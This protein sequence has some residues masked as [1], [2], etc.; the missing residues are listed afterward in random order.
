[1]EQKQNDVSH[2]HFSSDTSSRKN[3]TTH[4]I[5]N[6]KASYVQ[7]YRVQPI[8]NC[9]TDQIK[10][11]NK[12]CSTRPQT[13]NP[14]RQTKANADMTPKLVPTK[15][16]KVETTSQQNTTNKANTYVIK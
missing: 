15:K 11:S 2:L 10:S 16:R 13:Q 1:M 4:K 9:G 7:Q 8:L 3:K 5:K 12:K 6:E 14:K